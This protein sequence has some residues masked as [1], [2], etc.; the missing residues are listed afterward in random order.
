MATLYTLYSGYERDAFD[1]PIAPAVASEMLHRC[2]LRAVKTFGGYSRSMIQGGWLNDD[3][4]VRETSV[5]WEIVTDQ[6]MDAQVDQFA[7]FVR[8]QF[9]QNTV[10]V[11]AQEVRSKCLTGNPGKLTRAA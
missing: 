7:E 9:R 10:I 4:I 2:E 3:H 6:P 11:S 5:R 1:S 8:E